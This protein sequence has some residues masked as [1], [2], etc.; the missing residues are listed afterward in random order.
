MRVINKVTDKNFQ[1]YLNKHIGTFYT[2]GDRMN[3]ASGRFVLNKYIKYYYVIAIYLG[4]FMQRHQKHLFFDFYFFNL[5]RYM[6]FLSISKNFLIKIASYCFYFI[7]FHIWF[8]MQYSVVYCIHHSFL[9]MY[10]Y[11]SCLY[12]YTYMQLIY[13]RIHTHMYIHYICILWFTFLF[14]HI[15][16][17]Q[18]VWFK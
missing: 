8:C 4:F 11:A 10:I 1:V 16:F 7:Y 13:I 18:I 5:L 15:Y 6:I 17:L 2:A 3:N 12:L 14:I 9:C